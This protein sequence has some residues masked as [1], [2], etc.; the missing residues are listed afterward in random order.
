[1]SGMRVPGGLKNKNVLKVYNTITREKEEL[2]AEGS[3][4]KWYTCGPTVYDS[5]HLGHARS[6]LLMDTIRKT[7]ERYFGYTIMY[8]MNI[9]DVDDKIILKA[10][11]LSNTLENIEQGLK[12]LKISITE[13]NGSDIEAQK[14]IHLATQR[15]SRKYEE[16]FFKDM[17][18]LGVDKPTYTTRV[19]DYIPEIVQFIER[20]ENKG[21]AYESQGSVY[22]DISKYKKTH[23][24]PLMCATH[25][26]QELLE[27]GEGKLSLEG[28]RNKED[29]V[30][31]KKSKAEEP[32]W[33]S[34]W[35]QGRPGWHIECSV[36][37]SNISGGRI[38]LHSGGIDLMFPHHDNEIAQSEGYGYSG[39]VGHFIH[40]GHLHIDGLKMSKSLKNFIK[41]ETLL[42][43]STPREIRMMFLLQ[44]YRGPMKLN[45]ESKERAS[46]LEKKIFR[47]ISLY[48]TGANEDQ[49]PEHK[50][51]ITKPLSPADQEILTE[52]E[53]KILEIDSALKDDF[54][55]P[56]VL[57][58]I[59]QTINLGSKSTNQIINRNIA[60][61]IKDIMYVMGLETEQ[62][63]NQN[64]STSQLISIIGEFRNQIRSL[65]K[66]S[67]DKSSYYQA[68]DTLRKDLSDLGIVIED[69]TTTAKAS[70]RKQI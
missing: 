31:W 5:A 15:V 10:R 60:K 56:L 69:S 49:A 20:I 57:E 51:N 6:Y 23:K 13:E 52:F 25:N 58:T 3:V 32:A 18:A 41:V 27:E 36:M 47:Y 17:A 37:A 39:W 11:E 65:T 26:Q 54:N 21:L 50:N 9:T 1:M 29:F 14:R 38:D 34:K 2:K 61:Y 68:C 19:S 46:A 55:Y 43:T 66:S 28:K 12:D 8:I 7:L 33:G 64:D 42:Q 45:E 30:L 59:S 48:S 63:T 44:L 24:Y 22:F 16:E 53:S 70:I 62:E 40:T 35:G 67:A 4:L